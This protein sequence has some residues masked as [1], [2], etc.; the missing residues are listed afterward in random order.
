MMIKATGNVKHTSGVR[1]D[2][3]KEQLNYLSKILE[4]RN[5]D[6]KI[7][8][9]VDNITQSEWDNLLQEEIKNEG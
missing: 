7:T 9:E 1:V 6:Y 4:K 3:T 2:L 8:I 5:L